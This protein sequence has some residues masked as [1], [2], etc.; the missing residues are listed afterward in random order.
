MELAEELK[1]RDDLR[2][3]IAFNMK[4][5]LKKTLPGLVETIFMTIEHCVTRQFVISIDR[6][7][8]TGGGALT[9]GLDFF[10]EETLGIP[11]IKWNPL[12]NNKVVGYSNKKAGFF[13]PV[14]L[15][16]AFEK[17]KK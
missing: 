12:D 11:T 5:I 17:Q 16:L 10:I 4:N 7:V 3:Q 1:R 15:G 9:E 6:I 2:Q 8:V 14:A 13:L